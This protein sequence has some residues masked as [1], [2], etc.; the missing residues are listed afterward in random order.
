MIRLEGVTKAYQEGGRERR[1]LSGADLVVDEGGFVCLM[2][3]SGSGKSTLLNV[4][5][6]IDTP[7]AGRVVVDGIDLAALPERERTLYRRRHMGFVFQFF[8]LVPTLTVGENVA[9]PLSLNGR[10]D[11]RLARD[12]LARVGLVER[13]HSFPDTLSGG[14]QQR[15]AVARA[16]VHGPSLVLADEPTGNLDAD[17]AE[18]VLALL[19][20]LCREAGTTLLVASHGEEVARR[21]DRVVLLAG[22]R[23]R[24]RGEAA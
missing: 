21:A 9:M 4:I 13:A 12:W 11:A 10:V 20:G 17:T 23:L 15:V 7:D 22:G 5:S 1:V 14:E 3:R 6:G 18:R 24:E 19:R 16:L 2:G 8:N